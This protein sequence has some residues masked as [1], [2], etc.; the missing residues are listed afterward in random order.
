MMEFTTPESYG[1]TTVN[2]AGI[3]VDG[4]I[5]YAGANNSATHKKATEDPEVQW[6]EPN[7]VEF[8]WNNVTDTKGC[9][10]SMACDLE[11]RADRVDVMA[12]VPAFIKQFIAGAA[13]TRPYIYQ[14]RLH[15]RATFLLAKHVE[16]RSRFHHHNQ[17]G[18]AGTRR[19]GKALDGSDVCL[20]NFPFWLAPSGYVGMAVY[21]VWPRL[22]RRLTCATYDPNIILRAPMR[23]LCCAMASPRAID[24]TLHFSSWL[25][26]QILLE[27]PRLRLLETFKRSILKRVS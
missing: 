24:T 11:K 7:A 16:V 21:V 4:K 13:G 26:W 27:A 6:P 15:F 2:V 9:H 12:E 8:K 17:G 10:A 5:V 18:W 3:A 14:V 1:S 23:R 25:R 20:L 19:V 22:V